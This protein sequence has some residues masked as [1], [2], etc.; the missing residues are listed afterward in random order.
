MISI[1]KRNISIANEVEFIEHILSVCDLL[2]KNLYHSQMPFDGF[3]KEFGKALT[4]GDICAI[5]NELGIPVGRFYGRSKTVPIVTF[6]AIRARLEV[7]KG[8]KK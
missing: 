6:E 2:E 8:V 1:E 3:R 4:D 5:M 7:L